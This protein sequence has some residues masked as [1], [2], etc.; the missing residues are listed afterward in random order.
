[1]EE[2]PVVR[3][4]ILQGTSSKRNRRRCSTTSASI[5]GYSSG[6]L[7]LN[8]SS[9]RRFTPTNPDVGSCTALPRIGRS[10]SRKKRM[11][12]AQRPLDARSCSVHEARADDHFAA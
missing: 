10:T 7:R 11:P 2:R 3:G 6:K 12:R 1:M 5:S 8:T 9:A 4:R